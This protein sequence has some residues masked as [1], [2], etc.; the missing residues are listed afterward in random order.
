M[1][2]HWIEVPLWPDCD[3]VHFFTPDGF[4]AKVATRVI[5]DG[6]ECLIKIPS[7]L[8]MHNTQTSFLMNL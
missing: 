8:L 5:V 7:S 1:S 6:T 4:K 2:L 3:V